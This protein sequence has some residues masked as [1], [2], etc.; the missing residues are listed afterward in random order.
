[1]ATIY[2]YMILLVGLSLLLGFA[3]VNTLGKGVLGT[4]G[5]SI[6]NNAIGGIENLDTISNPFNVTALAILLSLSAVFTVAAL[7]L[8]FGLSESLKIGALTVFFG[9]MLTE[10]RAIMQTAQ[11]HDSMGGMITLVAIVI[12]LPIAIGSVIAGYNWIGGSN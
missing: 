2:G 6:N 4:F 3:G 5:I 11:L 1:M 10:F 8:R 9:V 7:A 12:Y